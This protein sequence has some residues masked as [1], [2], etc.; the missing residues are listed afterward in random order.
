M[1]RLV[2]QAHINRSL[3]RYDELPLQR[4]RMATTPAKITE[5]EVLIS[6]ADPEVLACRGAEPVKLLA[7]AEDGDDGDEVATGAT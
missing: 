4:R 3:G 2:M 6:G 7:G 1:V 5:R